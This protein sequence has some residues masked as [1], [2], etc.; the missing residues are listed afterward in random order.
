MAIKGNTR[1]GEVCMPVMAIKK[2]CDWGEEGALPGLPEV[3][4]S[5]SASPPSG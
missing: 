4:V 3:S 2:W 5:P 1:Q